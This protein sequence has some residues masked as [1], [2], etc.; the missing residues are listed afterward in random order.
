MKYIKI[1]LGGQVDDK[2]SSKIKN[3]IIKELTILMHFIRCNLM[4]NCFPFVVGIAPEIHKMSILKIF[5]SGCLS[6]LY[7]LMFELSNQYCGYIEDK[8]NK[9]WRP[10]PSGMTTRDATFIRIFIYGIIYE[11][12]GLYMEAFPYTT[13]SHV[14]FL[15][16]GHAEFDVHWIP[17]EFITLSATF[18]LVGMTQMVSRGQV[19]LP[20]LICIPILVWLTSLFAD[21]RDVPGDRLRGRKYF[22]IVWGD[23]AARLRITISTVLSAI[24]VA[25]FLI[26]PLDSPLLYILVAGWPFLCL[27]L[28]WINAK[29]QDTNIDR[30]NFALLTWWYPILF[31]V[32][33]YF[34]SCT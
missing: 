25:I 4:I 6:I 34:S 11:I 17:Q 24:I 9:P 14:A 12:L 16:Y 15:L 8:K 33:S 3:P 29:K 21:I 30:K 28:L 7:C 20:W 2:Q 26:S 22:A 5:L 10:I 31:G 1:A 18:G 19:N 13:I 32:G 27:P 23:V